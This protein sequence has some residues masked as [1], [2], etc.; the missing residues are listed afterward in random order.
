MLKNVGYGRKDVF[1]FMLFNH[2]LGYREMCKKLD[3]CRKWKVRV[4]DCRYR[5]LDSV[6]DGY[7][8]GPKPQEEGDY[9]I[10]Q[11]WTDL[12]VRRFRQK[13]RQQNIA[14]LLD[15]PRG[16]YVRGCEGGKVAAG[17]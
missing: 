15:L 12:Q 2:D 17:A 9:Y 8:P 10:H 7:R 13:V 5:P 4:I 3:A 6:S 11:G 14:I 1:V 16:R